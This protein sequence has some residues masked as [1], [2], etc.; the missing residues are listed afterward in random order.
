MV[1]LFRSFGLALLL[2]LGMGNVAIAASFDCNKAATETEIVICSDPELSALDDR[3]HN[4]F[5]SAFKF[6]N[7]SSSL[8][9]LQRTWISDRDMCLADIP[10]LKRSYSSQISKT[11]FEN[12]WRKDGSTFSFKQ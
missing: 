1:R 6:S 12:C 7:A 10:C 11:W 5:R 3:M 9:E 8:R 2:S 4:I